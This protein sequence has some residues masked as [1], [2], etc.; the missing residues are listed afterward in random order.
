M[1]EGD[2]R[3]CAIGPDGA[4]I[5]G[6]EP[7]MSYR[8][9][10]GGDT[11]RR[12]DPIDALPTRAEWTFPPPPHEP[13]VLSI[14]FLPEDPAALLAGVEVGGVILSP[15]RG[16]TW[17]ERNAGLY[18]DV[19]SVR[20]DPSQPGRLLAVTGSGFYAS[21]DAGGSWERR[22]AG[23]DNGYT[24]GLGIN[25]DRAGEVLVAAGDRPP[26]MNGRLYHSLDAGQTWIEL[27]D[28]VLPGRH[29]R[30]PV[31][32]FA[33]NGAWI[34]TDAGAL[35]RAQSAGGPWQSM[36]VLPAPINAVVAGGSPSS[37]MH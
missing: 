31:P 24:V 8:S 16:E 32:F 9:D 29:A 23:M 35:F 19:H 5:A 13:H 26:G 6:V 1:W 10:D 27:T 22:M 37:I 11:W 34:G 30:A 28:S 33:E 12:L 25:P 20:P 21:E 15:D 36:H 18:V 3:S 7:A 14:D 4:L 17:V 2:A